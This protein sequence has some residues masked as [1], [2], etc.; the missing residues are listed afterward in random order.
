MGAGGRGDGRGCGGYYRGGGMVVIGSWCGS[1]SQR[2]TVALGLPLLEIVVHQTLPQIMTILPSPNNP[3]PP[4]LSNR[5]TANWG[6]TLI[7]PPPL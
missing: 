5:P 6:P 2:Y 1:G 7:N 4:T 3:P